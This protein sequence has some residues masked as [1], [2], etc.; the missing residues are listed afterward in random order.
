MQTERT[1]KLKIYILLFLYG[2]ITVQ[3]SK[4]DIDPNDGNNPDATD[5]Y[6]SYWYYSYK[7]QLVLT[8][9]S[10]KLT[11]AFSPYTIAH[12]GDTLFIA[13]SADNSLLLIDSETTRVMRTLRSWTF[14]GQEKSFNSPIEAIVPVGNR[15]YV[16]ERQSRIHV[17]KLPGFQYIACIG[18]GNYNGP[19]FQAQAMDVAD[20]LIFARDK[21][22]SVSIY[23]EASVTSQNSGKID[24]YRKAA[25]IGTHNNS[26]APHK[27]LADED[28]Y[29]LLTDY[30]GR[31]IR[32]LNPSLVNDDMENGSSIDM[33]K[34]SLDLD[35]K[36]KSLIKT[37]KHLYIT[38]DNNAINIYDR[39]EHKWNNKLKSVNG[40]T[41]S[42]PTCICA[43][44]DSVFWISDTH[45][46]K[47]ALIKI[48]VYKGEIREE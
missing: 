35:F 39:K 14:N 11:D 42:Q 20:G 22:G 38:G 44:N 21:D 48:N 37:E 36:P 28:G 33:A 18:N 10:L 1:M 34:L 15:L 16:A 40:Y 30:E 2:I 43:Q 27:M 47:Q 9:E 41:F 45:N 31:K 13:N 26:F 32:L 5:Q 23:Q 46:S 25:G 7:A 12:S 4:D 8:G 6:D 3:C 19:V 17:F 24:R 29:L